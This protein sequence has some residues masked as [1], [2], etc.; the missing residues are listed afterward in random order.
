MYLIITTLFGF[1]LRNMDDIILKPL[2]GNITYNKSQRM[3]LEY[4]CSI[5]HNSLRVLCSTKSKKK[6]YMVF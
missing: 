3:V 4:Y 2:I 1:E 5:A 6:V